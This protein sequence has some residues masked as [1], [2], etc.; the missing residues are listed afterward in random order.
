MSDNS[1]VYRMGNSLYINLTNRC[2]CDCLFCERG[3]SEKVGDSDSLW[4]KTE[5][6][7]EQV[8]SGIF[9]RLIPE[10]TEIVF[11]GFGEPTIRFDD[12]LAICAAIK[13]RSDI[14]VRLNTNGLACL[15]HDR[16]VTPE[17]EGLV[18]AV[19]VSLNAPGAV[20]YAEISRPRFG[21]VA[22][23][24]VR[25]FA[26]NA[27]KYVPRVTFTIVD[28]LPEEQ[29]ERCRRLAENNG[30]PLRIRSLITNDPA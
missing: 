16:D 25:N 29:T 24:A 9:E 3:F 12:I 23:D 14:P 30:V 5:P 17:L 7:V 22:F 13:A 21:A 27:K 1:V 28:T 8:C 6:T 2:N 15:E 4:L 10:I 19:S 20:E 11:C 18:D 26:V